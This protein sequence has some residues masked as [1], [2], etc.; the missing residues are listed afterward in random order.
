MLHHTGSNTF[1]KL[2]VQATAFTLAV[3]LDL[4]ADQIAATNC[5]PSLPS[6]PFLLVASHITHSF[7]LS[8]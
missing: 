6:R 5:V 3:I 2:V 1:H 8:H 4:A 7:Q